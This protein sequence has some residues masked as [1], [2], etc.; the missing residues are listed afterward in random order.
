M[1]SR[2]YHDGFTDTGGDKFASTMEK[3]LDYQTFGIVVVPVAPTT[4][5][6]TPGTFIGKLASVV[7]PRLG[8]QSD[9]VLIA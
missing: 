9:D 4:L 6:D 8:W 2:K 7:L 5:R 1:H 3:D